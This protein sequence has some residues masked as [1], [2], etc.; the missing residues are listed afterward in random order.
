LRFGVRVDEALTTVGV[1][2]ARDGDTS[3][4]EHVAACHGA[5]VVHA[6]V[7]LP[8]AGG[9]VGKSGDPIPSGAKDGVVEVDVHSAGVTRVEV[10]QRKA[11]AHTQVACL[12]GAQ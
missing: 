10:N 4:R 6:A 2:G 5:P 8:G 12:V 11:A 7:C 9:G 3:S 1:D